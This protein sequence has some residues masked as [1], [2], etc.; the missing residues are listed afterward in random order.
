[1]VIRLM[2]L[3]ALSFVPA[4]LASD[5]RSPPC[6]AGCR[7]EWDK[8]LNKNDGGI[9]ATN[10]GGGVMTIIADGFPGECD[11]PEGSCAVF[12]LNG[13]P[14][15]CSV[16]VTFSYDN[17]VS[18]GGNNG[19]VPYVEVNHAVVPVA[20]NPAPGSNQIPDTPVKVEECGGEKEFR[21]SKWFKRNDPNQEF[22]ITPPITF[23]AACTACDAD[24]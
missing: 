14:V 5:E 13:E 20:P 16:A 11:C 18:W 21:I 8:E 10:P 22:A 23:T 7:A 3:A 12:L 24:C 2:I 17:D 4:P 19:W 1:M 15:H 6:L 9:T